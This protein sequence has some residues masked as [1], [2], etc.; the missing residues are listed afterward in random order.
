LK[1][2]IRNTAESLQ[3][4]LEA[5]D[6]ADWAPMLAEFVPATKHY[7]EFEGVLAWLTTQDCEG[8][9]AGGGNP[10]CAIRICAKEK[11]LAGCWECDQEPCEKLGEIDEGYPGVVENRQRIREIGL[12]AW[13]AEQ[14]AEVEAGFSYADPLGKGK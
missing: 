14:K 7:P 3:G 1:G 4:L 10:D 6:Y 13:L 5:Y 8:C 2:R 11:G 12:E 9:P